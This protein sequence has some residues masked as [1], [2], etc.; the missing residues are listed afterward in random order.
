MKKRDIIIITVCVTTALVCIAL[1]FW[2][3]LRNNG[4][5]TT[6]AFVGVLAS[7][8]GV[9]ATII[10]GFQIAS[11]LELRD[12]KKQVALVEKQREELETYK[13][14][15]ARDI[16]MAKTGVANAFGI[17]SVVEKDSLLGF[18]ARVCSIVCDNLNL[19]LGNILLVRYRQLRQEIVPF[20]KTDDYIDEIYPIIQNLNYISIPKDKENYNEIMKLHFEILTLVNEMKSKVHSV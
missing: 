14:V 7:L 17:L 16:H 5:I 6:D 9:C 1:T 20:I 18:A 8:I 19:T 13:Q 2:G 12:V 11:F 15:I 3:N 4:T 10:V